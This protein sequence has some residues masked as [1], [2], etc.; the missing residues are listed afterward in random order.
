[1]R[2]SN[3]GLLA[4]AGCWT[5]APPPVASPEAPPALA[6]APPRVMLS[7]WEGRYVCAQGPTALKL[8]LERT[9][10][11]VEAIFDFGPLDDNPSVPHG[12][13]RLTGTLDQDE[14]VLTPVNWVEQPPHYMMVGLHAQISRGGRRMS[15]QIDHPS[16][17]AVD[18][19][20]VDR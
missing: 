20:R 7:T 8:T 1:V 6:I 16:C 11:E 12:T 5:E 3:L 9:G 13:Y 2:A 15:G 14:I 19:W 10:S 17:A 18:V 4:L